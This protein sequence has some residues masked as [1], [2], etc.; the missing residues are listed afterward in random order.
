MGGNMS[1]SDIIGFL[2]YL[3]I[4][5]QPLAVLSRLFED[6]QISYAGA[7]RI[8]EILETESEV[9]EKPDARILD[10][11]SGEIEFDDVSFYYNID[12][13]V[14]NNINFTAQP[15]EMIA[16]VG[17]TGVGKTT[18]VSLIERFYDPQSGSIKIDGKNIKD[19]T[20]ESLRSQISMV[21][22]DVFLFNGTIA[23]NISYSVKDATQE[24]I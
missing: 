5:Y 11:C 16:V 12:E 4:F 21:L 10:K 20:V 1:V 8:F 9:K 2:M 19:L 23:E 3:G 6:V 7:V 15:G 13:P 24:Q 18:I 14:L 17:P 22:Q